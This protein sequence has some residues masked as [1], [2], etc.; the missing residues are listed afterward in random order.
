MS[1]DRGRARAQTAPTVADIGVVPAH[2]SRVR[3]VLEELD[4]QAGSVVAL[5]L[6]WA[7]VWIVSLGAHRPLAGIAATAGWLA[8]VL[9]SHAWA[10]LY[11]VRRHHGSDG[12]RLR[13]LAHYHWWLAPVV[14]IGGILF[15]Y[16]VW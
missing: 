5:I 10:D 7:I 12:Y 3:T 11:H 1:Q 14:L 2:R 16:R 8:A 9:T 15:G 13:P 4:L 6:G